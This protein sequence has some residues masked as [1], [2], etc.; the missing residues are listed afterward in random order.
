MKGGKRLFLIILI[1]DARQTRILSISPKFQNTQTHTRIFQRHARQL[2]LYLH[3]WIFSRIWVTTSLLLHLEDKNIPPCFFKFHPFIT[4]VEK[5]VKCKWFLFE[6]WIHLYW[7]KRG[8]PP[9]LQF[10]SVHTFSRNFNTFLK[11]EY[12]FIMKLLITYGKS[13][14]CYSLVTL[15]NIRL[16]SEAISIRQLWH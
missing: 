14:S 6:F 2:C 5:A 12:P 10:G 16:D 7:S 1:L 9:T 3:D 13:T 11:L 15:T 8:I 4:A